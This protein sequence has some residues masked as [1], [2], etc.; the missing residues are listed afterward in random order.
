MS[1]KQYI[2]DVFRSFGFQVMRHKHGRQIDVFADQQALLKGLE[3]RC[4]FDVGAN[5]GQTARRYRKLFP[6]ATVHSFEPDPEVFRNLEAACRADAAIRPHQLA[7]ADSAGPR[8]YF[9]SNHEEWGSLSPILDGAPAD[10]L[11]IP[12]SI[13]T[14]SETE[15]VS[16]TL[17]DF[18]AGERIDRVQIL[19]MDIQGNEL[20]ALKGATRLLAARSIDLIYAEVLFKQFYQDQCFFHDLASVLMSHDY[21]L[22]GLYNLHFGK[23]ESLTVADAMWLSA[24]LWDSLS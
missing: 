13:A 1:M 20:L 18:C 12:C 23:H 7:V 21:T 15:V 24:R 19:K 17:D 5:V 14:Q 22:F 6:D 2:K 8:R 9:T 11:N 4:I 3:V 10:L 16:T